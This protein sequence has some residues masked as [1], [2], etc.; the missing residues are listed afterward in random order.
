MTSGLW[1][2][3]MNQAASAPF[4]LILPLDPSH[5]S[6][7]LDSIVSSIGLAWI[8]RATNGRPIIPLVQTKRPDLGLRPENLQAL[9]DSGLEHGA[10]E[11]LCLDEIPWTNRFPSN[12]FAL[13][14]HN[15][16]SGQFEKDNSSCKVI[17]IVDHHDDERCHLDA[18]IRVV[19]PAGSCASHVVKLLP[20]KAVSQELA[21]LLLS[22]ICID[23]SGL[24]VG[25]K[26]LPVDREAATFLLS[27]VGDSPISL[28]SSTEEEQLASLPFI[29]GLT[30]QL[31]EKKNSVSHLGTRDLLRRDYKQYS[32]NLPT[33]SGTTTV[34]AG[35]STVPIGLGS[36]I[37]QDPKEFWGYTKLWMEE[38]NLCVMGILTSFRGGKDIGKSGKKGKHMRQML[39]VI[40]SIPGKSEP[41]DIN[42][43]AAK[44]WDGIES[45]EELNVFSLNFEAF[46]TTEK[47]VHPSMR[48]KLYQ[49]GNAD[50]TR[51]VTAPLLKKILETPA[52]ASLCGSRSETFGDSTDM[53]LDRF[54]N[55]PPY[56]HEKIYHCNYQNIDVVKSVFP[57]K[58]HNL[59][60]SSSLTIRKLLNPTSEYSTL[61]IPI[62]HDPVVLANWYRIGN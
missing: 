59:G 23:T 48:V 24:K 54:Q 55:V 36:I 15:R 58:S 2:W 22:A 39:W 62:W 43:L 37:Q 1:S 21:L 50:A 47:E 11:L 61:E 27:K 9:F 60:E 46:G 51:K 49:Q 6:L 16:L 52:H 31:S 8:G 32:L 13:A 14:D 38:R 4:S 3:G 20:E 34:N 19:A 44:L 10:P 56:V 26:A 41:L 33:Q 17:S 45:S 53:P 29:R 30:I 7:D 5:I 25:G 18:N 40:R 35:I 57:P 42:T 12:T 28:S